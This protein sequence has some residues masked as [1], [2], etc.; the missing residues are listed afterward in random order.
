MTI[1]MHLTLPVGIVEYTRKVRVGW[2]LVEPIAEHT[3]VSK[4]R[5]NGGW[6]YL[7]TP[8]SPSSLCCGCLVCA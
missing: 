1:D 8:P 5:T 6:S 4:H 7:K 2:F 3:A